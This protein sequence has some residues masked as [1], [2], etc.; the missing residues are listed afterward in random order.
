MSKKEELSTAEIA[1]RVDKLLSFEDI[2]AAQNLK[3]EE[4]EVP[5]WGGKVVIRQLTK[6]EQDQVNKAATS[7]G[8]E[9]KPKVDADLLQKHLL[10]CGVK[11]PALT[12]E[13]V[14][15]LW[16]HAGS[17]VDT[18]IVALMRINGMTPE[19]KKKIEE[20]FRER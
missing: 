5:E 15:S 20:S 19:A 12:L 10:A 2:A 13:Q 14:E 6:R 3:T 1:K 18:V 4:V 8:E 16:D 9:G 7:T 17:A 11:E